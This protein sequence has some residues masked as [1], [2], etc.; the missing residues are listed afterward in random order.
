MGRLAFF[1]DDLVLQAGKD[2]DVACKAAEIVS[3]EGTEDREL[4][5]EIDDWVFLLVFDQGYNSLIILFEKHSTISQLFGHNS[6]SPG[7]I[8]DYG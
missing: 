7:I 2:I 4:D 1:Q 3:A 5:Y 6:S 8:S